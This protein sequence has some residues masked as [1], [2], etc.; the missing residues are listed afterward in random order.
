MQGIGRRTFMQLG[1]ATAATG[2]V[3]CDSSGYSKVPDRRFP[4]GSF[5]ADAT[6]ESVAS[7]L[8]LTG[9]TALVT[10]CNSGL[11]LETMRVLAARGAHVIGTGR[12]LEKA[13]LACASVA[14]ETTPAVLELSDFQSAVDC[15]QFLAS[16]D[17][18]LDMV[19]ANAGFSGDT[20]FVLDGGI[21]QTFRVNYLGHFILLNRILP[22]VHAADAGRV[23]HLSS[24][25]AYLRAPAGGIDFDSLSTDKG[26]SR[27]QKYG[28]SKLANALFSL[29]LAKQ[30]EGTSATSNSLHPGMVGT[31]IARSYPAW[32][33]RAYDS[34]APVVGKSVEEGAATQ[35]YLAAHPEVA[36][37]NGAY[38]EDCTATLV[39]GDSYLH[40][41]A[42][43]DTLWHASL[44]MTRDYL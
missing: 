42:L 38:F 16:L 5:S 37:V 15:A 35:V 7:G 25:A 17:R 44:D 29:Q 31:S 12:T 28:Q 21:E 24:A 4:V 23:I 22:L 1:V 43:A 14:G 19:V 18:P 9:K 34:L 30:F 10:G 13:E 32:F 6:A 8:N 11:G 27:L 40:D 20:E 41:E 26:L 36:G 33:R 39:E 3:A 2:L